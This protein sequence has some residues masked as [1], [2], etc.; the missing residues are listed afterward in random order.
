[1]T[2]LVRYSISPHI[3]TSQGLTEINRA[4]QSAISE[5]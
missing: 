3:K 2:R 4:I 5:I 1:M